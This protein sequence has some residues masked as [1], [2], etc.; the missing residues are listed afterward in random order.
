L[1]LASRPPIQA[2]AEGAS[3]H[4]G[5][6]IEAPAGRAVEAVTAV[7]VA[8]AA[9]ETLPVTLAPAAVSGAGED[10]AWLP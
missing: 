7:A 3:S 10:A 6:H 5:G 1:G 8:V 4:S 2:Q 9:A